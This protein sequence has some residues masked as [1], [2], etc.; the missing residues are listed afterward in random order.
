MQDALSLAGNIFEFLGDTIELYEKQNLE[1]ELCQSLGGTYLLKLKSALCYG[2]GL[3]E[4]RTHVILNQLVEN[5]DLP[6]L[7]NLQN[8]EKCATY[9]FLSFL[10]RN[11]RQ[12]LRIGQRIQEQ[13]DSIS[14][15][16]QQSLI[17]QVSH[18][19][20]SY[21]LSHQE[22]ID[23]ATSLS[24][25][26]ASIGASQ[27]LLRGN[28]ELI[29]QARQ[30][31]NNAIKYVSQLG[32]YEQFWII[33]TAKEILEKMW[34]NSPWVRLENVINRRTY[35]RKL[36]ED[37]IVTLWNSQIAALEMRSTLGTLNGGYLDER[38]K[39]VIVNMPTSAGKTLL[40]E[41]A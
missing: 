32:N 12:V 27:A 6:S 33:R 18:S 11:L 30:S 38:V 1:L 26:E 19:Q 41:T 23:I 15:F 39:R 10:S 17:G 21:Y 35:L 20:D 29:T 25:I 2:L 16:L 34:L 9:V 37:G 40:A 8:V 28:T 3:Y 24:L 5:L 22:I 14:D 7:C 4:A 36:V 31:F 13:I